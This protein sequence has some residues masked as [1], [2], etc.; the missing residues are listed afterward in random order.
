MTNKSDHA[1]HDSSRIEDTLR[2][3]L[4]REQPSNGFEDRLLARVHGRRSEAAL[5]LWAAWLRGFFRQ[6]LMRWAT[7]AALGVALI[8]SGIEYRKVQRERRERAEG[9]AAKQQLM[10]ALRIAG[11]KLQ[12]AKSRV[13]Q[14]NTARDR[15]GQLKN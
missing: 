1:L 4:R 6:P 13:N 10:L 2:Q 7:A 8:A 11:S 9:E 12:L 5:F 3:A 15:P 14:I